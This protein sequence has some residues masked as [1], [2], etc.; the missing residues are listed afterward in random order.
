MLS[1]N[2]DNWQPDV[3]NAPEMWISLHRTRGAR[4]YKYEE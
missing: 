3:D 2:V 1:T 4:V